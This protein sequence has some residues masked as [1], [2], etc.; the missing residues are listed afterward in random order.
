MT[1]KAE[2][3]KAKIDKWDYIKLKSFSQQNDK[4]TYRVEEN[5]CK[6]DILSDNGLISKKYKELIQ[7]SSKNK[8]KQ[9]PPKKQQKNL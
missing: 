2:A 5:I 1:P 4:A 3:T 9:P 6:P 7:L 8:T